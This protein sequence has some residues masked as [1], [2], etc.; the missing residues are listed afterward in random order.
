MATGAAG[1]NLRQLSFSGSDR[2]LSFEYP[3]LG[4]IYRG[5]KPVPPKPTE[6]AV[7]PLKDHT[8][9]KNTQLK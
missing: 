5:S 1:E 6:M 4:S 8:G 9:G 2:L 7:N 3:T